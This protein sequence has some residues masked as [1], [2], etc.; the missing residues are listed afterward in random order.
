[1]DVLGSFF[2]GLSFVGLCLWFRYPVSVVGVDCANAEAMKC[3]QI[4][5]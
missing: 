5:E 4:K 3:I 1:V 2:V